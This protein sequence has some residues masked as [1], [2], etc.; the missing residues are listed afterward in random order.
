MKPSNIILIGMPGSGKSTVGVIIAKQSCKA[1]LDTDVII[2]TRTGKTLQ[3]IVDREGYLALRDIEESVLLE[4]R[5]KDTVIA[6]GGSAVYSECAMN[7]LKENGMVVFLDADL[8]TIRSRVSDFG[9]RGLAKRPDQSLEE[10]FNERRPLYQQYA[11]LTIACKGM[12]HEEVSA[13]ILAT[14]TNR[15]CPTSH[16]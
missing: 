3:D 12:T 13:R 9:S 11:D 15:T 10:L 4:L 7:H 5:P 16:H 1:F 6:T 2:Q 14:T 8:P